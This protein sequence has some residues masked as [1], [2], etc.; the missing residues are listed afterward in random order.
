MEKIIK[1]DNL[2]YNYGEG[3]IL[4]NLS[5]E[6]T[7]G[8]F[9]AV[10]G[11]NGAGKSTLLRLLANI[12]EPTKGDIRIYD[13]PLDTFKH[14]EKIG[15]VPQNPAR[16]QK[17]FPIKVREVVELGLVNSG[18]IFKS[19]KSK[20]LLKVNAIINKFYLE[21][22]ASKKLGELSG[23]QQQRVFLARAMVNNPEILLLDEPATGID[24][25]AKAELYQML[26]D[27][28]EQE[29]KT[30][31]M[32]SHDLDLAVKYAKNAVCLDHGVCFF[33]DV[34]EA[35]NHHHKHGYFYR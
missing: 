34:K 29:G 33:G 26:G 22:L 10:I 4:H 18:N 25:E 15:Y 6:I 1:I 19:L 31:I 20:D 2:S 17:D 7:K 14:W 11:P 32:V 8:D 23:G 16:N 13:E 30:I 35:L 24:T 21:D 5:L 9:L 27:L 28:S 12:L 3:W